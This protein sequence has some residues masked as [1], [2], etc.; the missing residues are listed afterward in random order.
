[1]RRK[2]SFRHFAF[3]DL[4]NSAKP[5]FMDPRS[6]SK[7][8]TAEARIANASTPYRQ[9][10]STQTNPAPNSTTIEHTPNLRHTRPRPSIQVSTA[11]AFAFLS[12]RNRAKPEVYGFPIGVEDGD[13]RGLHCERKHA[14]QAATEHTNQTSVILGHDRVSKRT[15]AF[16][17]SCLA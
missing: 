3:L 5:E 4:R 14:I 16:S 10:P 7:M 6:G 8:A 1:M 2:G 9:R 15:K 12:L 11:N 13:C 17:T